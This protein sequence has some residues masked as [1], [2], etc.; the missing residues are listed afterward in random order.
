MRVTLDIPLPVSNVGLT[1]KAALVVSQIVDGTYRDLSCPVIKDSIY[2]FEYDL[3]PDAFRGS[4]VFYT[5]NL[6]GNDLSAV[7]V[8]ASC[9]IDAINNVAGGVGSTEVLS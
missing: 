7:V 4:L 1:L 9:P 6:S 2:H 8:R 5:G 3:I